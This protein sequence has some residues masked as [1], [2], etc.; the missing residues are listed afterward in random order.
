MMT[1]KADCKKFA[2]NIFNKSKCQHCFKTKEAHTAEALES[3]R[4][5][6][7]V[8]KCGYLFVAP[9]FDFSVTINRTKRW[10]RRWF[11]LYDDG[12]LTYSVDEHPD[13]VPQ[14]VIDMNKVLEVSDGENVTGNQFAI[15]I[16]APD[17]VHFI[18]GMSKE[19]RNWWFDILSRF[20][21]NTIRG[22]NKRFATIPGGKA[23][24]TNVGKHNVNSF[25]SPG[26]F[27][28]SAST[29]QRFNTFN[30]EFPSR[31]SSDLSWEQVQNAGT[32]DV[33]PT[34]ENDALIVETKLTSTPVDKHV[35][36]KLEKD[37]SSNW[38]HVESENL[39]NILNNSESIS[40]MPPDI[41]VQKNL[42]VEKPLT[43]NKVKAEDNTEQ[44]K[45]RSRRY[46][47][48]D[49][50]NARSLRIRS[51]GVAK[52]MPSQV[53][54]EI[55]KKRN[56]SLATLDLQSEKSALEQQNY[57]S[58][59]V[60]YLTSDV[61]KLIDEKSP[62]SPH[63]E[64]P[65]PLHRRRHTSERGL[66]NQGLLLDDNSHEKPQRD[67]GHN[68]QRSASGTNFS[69]SKWRNLGNGH[70]DTTLL[71]LQDIGSK[72]VMPLKP[73]NVENNGGPKFLEDK[74]TQLRGDPD[75][76]GLDPWS[77]CSPVGGLAQSEFTLVDLFLKKGWLLRQGHNDW[78]KHWFVLRNS[79]LTFYRD[80]N[81]EESNIMDGVL[82]LQLVKG[83]EELETDKNYAFFI[84]NYIE[85]NN[86][87]SKEK[88]EGS[89]VISPVCVD[90]PVKLV[91][92]SSSDDPSE[93][94]SIVDEEEGTEHPAS[95]RTLPPSPP[96]NRTAISRV[97]EKARSRSSSNS[98]IGRQ[99]RSPGSADNEQFLVTAEIEQQSDGGLSD[100]SSSSVQGGDMFYWERRTSH[101][102]RMIKLL[103][104]RKKAISTKISS[105]SQKSLSPVSSSKNEEML[106]EKDKIAK[107][108]DSN[109]ALL[110]EQ[111]KYLEEPKFEEQNSK[112]QKIVRGISKYVSEKSSSKE[113]QKDQ[114][115]SGSGENLYKSKYEFLKVKYKK[116]RAE[117]E[118]KLSK[119]KTSNPSRPGK[120]EDLQDALKNCKDQLWSVKCKLE[121]SPERKGDTLVS[122]REVYKLCEDVEKLLGSSERRS[123]KDNEVSK[124]KNSIAELQ[125]T[126]DGRQN[127]LEALKNEFNNRKIDVTK[128]EE[129]LKR[130]LAELEKSRDDKTNLQGQVRQ[131]EAVLRSSLH[132]SDGMANKQQDSLLLLENSELKTKLLT[133]TE[134][135]K[136]LKRR[137]EEAHQ[138]YDDLE[139][140]CYKLQQDMKKVHDTHFSQL[141]LMTARVD[142]LTL[143]LTESERNF[144]QTK[145]KLTRSESR[146]ERRKSS[147]RGKEGLN[148]TKE[149]EFKLGDLE[150]KIESIEHSLK[151]SQ[152]SKEG[153]EVLSTQVQTQ[154]SKL[155]SE[156]SSAESHG[157]LVRLSNLD[158]KVK[159]VYSIAKPLDQGSDNLEKPKICLQ[160]KNDS[161]ESGPEEWSTLS[162][163]NSVTD[164]NDLVAESVNEQPKTLSE[165]VISLSDKIRSLGV[166]F[167]NILYLIHQQED[168]LNGSVNAELKHLVD[169]VECLSCGAVENL[170]DQ[171]KGMLLEI[172]YQLTLLQEA[173]KAVDRLAN[174]DTSERK[175][176][177]EEIGRIH[178]WLSTL[179]RQLSSS[180]EVISVC[181]GCTAVGKTLC[182]FL[183]DFVPLTGMSISQ[184][185]TNS[186]IS[187]EQLDSELMTQLQNLEDRW[188]CIGKILNKTRVDDLA[189]LLS[190]VSDNCIS[191][192]HSTRHDWQS[193]TDSSLTEMIV[194][195]EI[196]LAELCTII[197]GT[198]LRIRKALVHQRKQKLSILCG[199]QEAFELWCTLIEQCVQQEL[200]LAKSELRAGITE[201]AS[202]H[203]LDLECCLNQEVLT[204]AAELASVVTVIGTFQGVLT[205]LRN[206]AEHIT[207]CREIKCNVQGSSALYDEQWMAKVQ[208][209]IYEQAKQMVFGAFCVLPWNGSKCVHEA[210]ENSSENIAKQ[211][212]SN[213]VSL[214]QQLQEK[215]AEER[216]Q[217]Q[218]E[219]T[220]LQ[221]RL[222][223]Q[224]KEECSKCAELRQDVY[225][226]QVQLNQHQ[227]SSQKSNVC[228]QCEELQNNLCE[229]EKKHA[230]EMQDL[231]SECDC[232]I[233][234]IRQDM[235]ELLEQQD[236]QHSEEISQLQNELQLSQKHLK[237]L[238]FEYDEQ[239]RSLIDIYHQKLE[240][241]HD[242][243]SEE[244]VRRRYQS[245]IEQ[246]KGLSEKGLMAME[247]SYKRMIAD[248]EKKHQTELEQL[249]NEKEKALAEETQATR[250]AL[251]AMR[252]AHK[253]ELQ[254]EIAKFKDEFLKQMEFTYSGENQYK[255]HEAELEEIK[256]EILSLSEKY[257]IKCLVNASLKESLELLKTQLE[258]SNYQV[259]DL[260]A[261]NKQLRAHLASEVADKKELLNSKDSEQGETLMQHLNLRDQELAEQKEENAELLQKLQLTENHVNLLAAQC[262]QLDQSLKAERRLRKDE[263]SSLRTKLET[264]VAS[265]SPG[266]EEDSSECTNRERSH[267][268]QHP[269]TRGSNTFSRRA[270]EPKPRRSHSLAL[271]SAQDLM[272]SPSC[273]GLDGLPGI[274][275]WRTL[276]AQ[277]SITNN[278]QSKAENN[279]NI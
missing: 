134:V 40:S 149:F 148:L 193:V 240:K 77:L 87:S 60:Y 113:K 98:R 43:G 244:S 276:S 207:S 18:K 74:N 212:V 29:R 73:H 84:T 146:Q 126:C 192:T 237:H 253:E 249:E 55:E 230:E 133:V 156:S 163:A 32:E 136:S 172:V 224:V 65:P 10:Q 242:I 3:N 130:T 220:T 226:L 125:K 119:E 263:V 91:D 264:L 76:C 203:Q 173:V 144:R 15:A 49:G 218:L 46:L 28:R 152:Q 8:S 78:Y 92:V 191:D 198:C 103:E 115:Q 166:W 254:R 90:E 186:V 189:A 233:E 9:D 272:R 5:S 132:D 44:I 215:L 6:R 94:F 236:K 259:F 52:M 157:F 128:L 182:V 111:C 137:L 48:R 71:S 258:N 33:F 161:E 165:C 108:T 31:P 12:E 104:N 268:S 205:Y 114:K 187:I 239:L 273:P 19:E 23:T 176:I 255:E 95:P 47:K 225:Q 243:I 151:K 138:S 159:N 38:K 209:C 105:I 1:L 42:E 201:L 13:T 229:L 262:L 221:K 101:K 177:V 112:G 194:N 158:T 206:K 26:D 99:L 67:R 68:L 102:Q 54:R 154:E 231:K 59:P 174:F 277:K 63:L 141:A 145:Q 271:Y 110:E 61:Q 248:L 232:K 208:A 58:N 45:G 155:G 188:K 127:E 210:I 246:W 139:I 17:K 274:E 214:Q 153:N 30:S 269:S 227:D 86:A 171:D 96:L 179:E 82:D 278:T 2:P 150:Q 183:Q 66:A 107:L 170:R 184:K 190:C 200:D 211:S 64:L 213:L 216:F 79:S 219:L 70:R 195:E 162:L 247:N 124:L 118:E 223:Q 168:S 39:R 267:T 7:K 178:H 56:Q 135:T 175:D 22:R 164:L 129:K 228:N 123:K 69:S 89:G 260:L 199:D 265:S 62:E 106:P 121:K 252:K 222:Q 143:K 72:T 51:D 117:W 266:S 50:R 185:D 279:E 37:D 120:A 36:N 85:E 57:C 81:A 11:V 83:V 275:K 197:T 181:G 238:E 21:S 167:K 4:A 202:L 20:P 97:K 24:V 116:D 241:K 109:G 270:F 140:N 88:L 160:I 251:D 147:L 14:A 234:I 93:Y 204:K 80:P 169:A 41:K 100:R 75:G 16:T 245:E 217:F 180:P 53:N 35:N 25:D 235:Q 142:D 257:S 250:A 122:W 256:H 27:I 34:K 131:L 196:V 261:R